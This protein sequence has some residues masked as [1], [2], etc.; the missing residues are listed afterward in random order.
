MTFSLRVLLVPAILMVTYP[1]CGEIFGCP[2]PVHVDGQ[3]GPFDYTDPID[4]RERLPIVEGAHF[5]PNV[6]S[7]RGG[8]SD[9]GSNNPKAAA[10]DLN[11]TLRAFPNHHRALAAMIRLSFKEN[12]PKP[13]GAKYTIECWLD[14]AVRWRPEDGAARMLYGNYLSHAKVK[15]YD[16]ALAQYKKA[17]ELLKNQKTVGNLYY[18]MGLLYFNKKDYVKARDFANKAYDRGFPLSGLKEMLIRIGKW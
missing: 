7:L 4:F 10:G 8:G 3:Y 6:E 18:N 11:Y 12:N 16:D 5:T 15:R 17:E 1:A 2:T 13:P 9:A 14:R